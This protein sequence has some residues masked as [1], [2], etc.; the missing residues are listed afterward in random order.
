MPSSTP[1]R[2]CFSRHAAAA[3]AAAL[4]LTLPAPAGAADTGS[5]GVSAVVLSKNN[6]RFNSNALTISFAAIDP[7]GGSAVTASG[8]IVFRCG[9]SSP[10]AS[11]SVTAGNGLYST[12][13]GARRMRHASDTSAFMAYSLNLPTSGTVPKNTDYTLTI[14]A[15]IQAAD[16]QNAI[17]GGYSD[18][19]V[20]SVTP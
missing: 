4:G 2:H 5:L 6:C 16:F 17:A 15:T 19:V 1:I 14:T 8:D 13:P 9:G 7:S 12:G 20:V 18:T 10:T 11:W 3:A